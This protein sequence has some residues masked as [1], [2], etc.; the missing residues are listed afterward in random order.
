MWSAYPELTTVNHSYALTKGTNYIDINVSK[1]SGS[2]EEA[3]VTILMEDVMVE[4]GYTNEQGFVR[5]PIT[6]NQTG[7]VLITVTKKNHYPYQNSFQIYDPGV[8]INVSENPLELIDDNT[9]GSIGNSNSIA[10]SGETLESFLTITN[11][12][13]ENAS[14]VTATLSTQNNNVN[15]PISTITFGD[16]TW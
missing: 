9:G 13:S 5:L 4:S 16:A 15:L 14:N 10:N 11:Y 8:S 1:E 6:T 7:E 2:V 12:G 3:W